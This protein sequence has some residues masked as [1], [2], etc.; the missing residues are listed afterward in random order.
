ML[1]PGKS[2]ELTVVVD[3]SMTAAS[4]GNDGVPVFGTPTLV[5]YF[6]STAVQLIAADLEPEQGSV[7]ARIDIRHL[8]PTPV[9]MRIVFRA[10]LTEVDGRRLVFHLV[11]EDEKERVGEGTHERFLI[12]MDRFLARVEAKQAG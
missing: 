12:D 3:E 2:A 10:T 5:R 11:A 9:G 6:E 1:E 7:G 8:A 4:L